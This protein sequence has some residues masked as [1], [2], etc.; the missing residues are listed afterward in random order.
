MSNDRNPAETAIITANTIYNI[1]LWKEIPREQYP[2]P[3][4]LI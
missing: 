4:P 3:L 2:L 1:I